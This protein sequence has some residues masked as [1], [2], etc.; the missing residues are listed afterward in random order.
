MIE[1]ISN[2]AIRR[3]FDVG[4]VEWRIGEE[5]GQQQAEQ[6]VPVAECSSLDG[7][8]A[9]LRDLVLTREEAS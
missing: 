6:A 8:R 2:A 7:H 1:P 3:Y 5:I 4:D 9:V